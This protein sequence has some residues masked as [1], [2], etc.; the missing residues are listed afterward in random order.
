MST[1]DHSS[2][3]AAAPRV[4]L[5]DDDPFMLELLADMLDDTSLEVLSAPW[6]A[7]TGH[8]LPPLG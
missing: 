3:G 6:V 8:G 7:V 5:L 4:L 1:P 2:P